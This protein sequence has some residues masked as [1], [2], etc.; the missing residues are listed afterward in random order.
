MFRLLVTGSR[1]NPDLLMQERVK[2]ALGM[3]AYR[4]CP[5]GG[6]L[7]HGDATGVD[8]IASVYWEDI[9]PR[10]LAKAFPYP[11]NMG[12]A[13]GPFRNQQMVT[14]GADLCLAFPVGGS[15]GTYDCFKKA[16]TALIPAFLLRNFHDMQ[17]FEQRLLAKA[18]NL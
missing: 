5:E 15:S 6:L 2:Y 9:G 10:H 17:N 8:T 4:L 12:K 18:Y 1:Q 3:V 7:L 11:S 16:R 13:G 14:F